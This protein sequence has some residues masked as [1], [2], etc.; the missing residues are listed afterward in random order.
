MNELTTAWLEAA[1]L[2][3]KTAERL[4]DDDFFTPVVA[5]HS[6]QC[7]EKALKAVLEERS[8]AVPKIHNV[9]KLYELAS[10][11]DRFSCDLDVLQQINDVYIDARYPGELGLL[12]EGKPTRDDAQRFYAFAQTIYDRVLSALRGAEGG[13]SAES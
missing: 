2:D 12:P 4:C 3:V 1:L 13:T 6:Q 8:H 11:Y 9:L 10:A 7:V 5:F